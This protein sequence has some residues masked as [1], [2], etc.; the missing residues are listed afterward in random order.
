MTTTFPILID[1]VDDVLA[2][3]LH[4]AYQAI[5][6]LETQLQALQTGTSPS[7]FDARL[8]LLSGT[9]VPDSDQLAKTTLYL[10]PYQG[11]TVGVYSGA[12]WVVLNTPEVAM[13]LAG[14]AA[15]TNYDVYAYLD[16][17]AIKLEAVAWTSATTRATALGMLDNILVKGGDPTRRYVGTIRT[18]SAAG[19]CEDSDKRRFVW[20][21]ANRVPRRIKVIESANSWTNTTANFRPFNNSTLNRVEVVTGVAELPVTLHFIAFGSHSAGQ[22]LY[23][24]IGLDSISWPSNDLCVVAYSNTITPVEAMFN[25]VLS[26]GYHF[27]QLLETGASTITW[28]GDYGTSFLQSGAVGIVWA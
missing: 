23:V 11:A 6:A 14:L 24:G 8:T 18:T 21:F 15:Y 17:N 20:N 3:H 22:S 27:L 12:K 7:T 9:P 28:Y 26:E 16:N 25:R 19:Q 13:P 5:N 10:T 2:A 1:H 4:A